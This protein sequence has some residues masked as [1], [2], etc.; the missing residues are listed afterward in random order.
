MD[1]CPTCGEHMKILRTGQN[2]AFVIVDEQGT[3]LGLDWFDGRAW[4]KTECAGCG[5]IIAERWEPLPPP[6]PKIRL[7]Q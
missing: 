1:P 3:E 7:V 6:D 4:E 2:H 5:R